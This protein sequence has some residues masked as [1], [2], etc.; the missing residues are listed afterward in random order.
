[1]VNI[2]K[3]GGF[4]NEIYASD[5]WKDSVSVY[6]RWLVNGSHDSG[7]DCRGIL[8]LVDSNDLENMTANVGL[9]GSS[10]FCSSFPGGR[11]TLVSALARFIGR[12]SLSEPSHSLTRSLILRKFRHH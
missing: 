8:S 11:R 2:V 5:S 9:E 4:E 6:G 12:P 3:Y 10:M 7:N 1:M